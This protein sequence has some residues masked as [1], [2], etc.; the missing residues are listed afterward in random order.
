VNSTHT[1]EV[2]EV[3]LEAH[4]NADAL[5]IVRIGGYTVCVN[6]AQWKD[7]PPKGAYIVP[8]SVVDTTRPEFAFLHKGRQFEV[9]KV[10]KLRGVYSQGLLIPALAG[11]ELGQNVA[12]ELG[13]THYEPP[14]TKEKLTPGDCEAAP[15]Q[16]SKYDVD[17]LRKY[18]YVLTDGEPVMVTEKCHGQNIGIM[19]YNDRLY[20]R[21]RSFWRKEGDNTFWKAVNGQR[22]AIEAFCRAYPEHILYG[23][24]VGLN[25]GFTYG[26]K[27]GEVKFFAFDIMKPDRT[28]INA[29][30]ARSILA[31]YTIAQV[32]TFGRM[33]YDFDKLA[34]LV[35]N[36]SPFFPSN[37]CMEGVVV[38]PL[39]ERYDN[40]CGRVSLKLVS[41]TYLEK[42]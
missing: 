5:S 41:N 20:V 17:T 37:I 28:F 1:V 23:E 33:A 18:R 6:T 13:V 22:E 7:L 3:N 36:P 31:G 9:I 2:V 40:R 42:S 4:P 32:P 10:K 15:V 19:F 16:V 11:W 26:C 24:V 30:T 21:S 14:A 34:E 39:V 27:P 12:D 38:K 35:E 29:E 8:E 25:K